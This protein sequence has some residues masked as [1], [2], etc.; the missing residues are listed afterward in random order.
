MS[1]LTFFKVASFWND[2]RY[3]LINEGRKR[4]D[5]AAE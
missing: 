4:F 2:D 5:V 1:Y 3:S